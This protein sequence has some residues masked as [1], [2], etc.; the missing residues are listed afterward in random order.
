ME[1]GGFEP[2]RPTLPLARSSTFSCST[3]LGNIPGNTHVDERVLLGWVETTRPAPAQVHPPSAYR[4]FC[5][6]ACSALACSAAT[7]WLYRPMST[8]SLAS[9]RCHPVRVRFQ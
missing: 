9:I 7:A 2:Q 4:A 3:P 1:G 5:A 6:L 8:T